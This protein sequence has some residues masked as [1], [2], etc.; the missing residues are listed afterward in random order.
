LTKAKGI[1]VMTKNGQKRIV[2]MMSRIREENW[3]RVIE[4]H[5]LMNRIVFNRMVSD[6]QIRVKK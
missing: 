3:R 4:N 6:G 5:N 1:G 2:G